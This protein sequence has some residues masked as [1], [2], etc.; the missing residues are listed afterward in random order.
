MQSALEKELNSR[1]LK[2]GG[3]LRSHDR[4]VLF[5][6]LISIPP[7]PPLPVIGFLLSLVNFWLWKSGALDYSEGR[8]IKI[9]LALSVLSIVIGV[10]L[11]LYALSLMQNIP[12]LLGTKASIL[13]SFF[14][15]LREFWQGVLGSPRTTRVEV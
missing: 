3:W 6:L 9:T 15:F 4:A 14:D 5:A 2:F 10:T 8:L 11:A 7:F 1:F 13:Q 12:A